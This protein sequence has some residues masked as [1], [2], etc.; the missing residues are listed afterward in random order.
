[1]RV[2][3]FST[4]NVVTGDGQESQRVVTRIGLFNAVSDGKYLRYLADAG[5]LVEFDRQP[6][7]RYLKLAKG[8]EGAAPGEMTPMALDPSRGAILGLLVQAPSLKERVQQGK[9]VGYVIIAL[10]ILGL[11]L[12]AERFISLNLQGGKI[13]RQLKSETP[14]KGNALG[15]VLSVYNDN[16]SA[17][18]ESLELK[19]DDAI[20]KE[21]PKLER[22]LAGIKL[23]AG[24]APLL[25]LLGTVTG[26]IVTFQT[27]TLFGTGDPKLMAGGISQ[28]LMTTVL[29]LVVAIPLLLLHSVLSTKSK[30]LV[31]I[32]DEES[33]GIVA[34]T[35]EK[36]HGNA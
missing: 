14:D 21:T 12:A 13:K 6:K 33:A 36:H 31:Q 17:D 19:L 8:L 7:S 11:L 18:V 22:G 24:I 26:M 27:I 29:G 20:L 23:L 30:R 10:G 25:G 3:N 5:K 2:A 32:L 28:A 35:A 16:P 15:R 9:V 34:M 1:M 4:H